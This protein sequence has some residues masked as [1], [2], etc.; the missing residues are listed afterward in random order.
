[1]VGFAVRDVDAGCCGALH[2]HNGFLQ[3]AHRMATKLTDA[4]PDDLP[5]IVDAAG[6]GSHL[7]EFAKPSDRIFDATEFLLAKGLDEALRGSAGVS[8]SATYHDACHL[9][10]GQGVREQPRAL[11]RAVPGLNLVEMEEPD[12]CCGSG[13]VYNLTQPGRA[14]RLLERKWA[15]IARTGVDFVVM[16]NPGCQTWIDQA[17]REQGSKIKVVH[18]L[19]MLESSFSGLRA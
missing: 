12:M 7:K 15:N 3:E 18:T 11:L 8:A 13:G 4:M 10:H 5:I 16:G 2:A 9:A 17:S 14:R 6:C 1:R 19:E